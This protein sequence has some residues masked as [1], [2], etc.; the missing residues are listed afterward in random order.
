MLAVDDA[1]AAVKLESIGVKLEKD[2][3]HD[4]HVVVAAGEDDNLLEVFRDGPC[5]HKGYADIQFVPSDGSGA[6][7]RSMIS[8]QVASLGASTWI[9]PGLGDTTF[10]PD[11]DE[12]RAIVI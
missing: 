9:S 4:E 7:A 10:L 6:M 2:D 1:T 3:E 12:H 11:T 8:K 5:I